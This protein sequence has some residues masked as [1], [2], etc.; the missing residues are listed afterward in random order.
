MELGPFSMLKICLVM[1]LCDNKQSFGATRWIQAAYSESSMPK[2]T[3]VR[4][5]IAESCCQISEINY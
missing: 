3:L 4:I 2:A 5:K 1:S